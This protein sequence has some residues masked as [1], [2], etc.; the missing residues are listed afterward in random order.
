MNDTNC[1]VA[2]AFTSSAVTVSG[3]GTY[4]SGNFIP[5]T[6]GTYYWIATYTG[7]PPNTSGPVSTTCGD[8]GETSVVNPVTP[9]LTTTAT[10]SVTVGSPIDDTAHLGGT[11]TKPNGTPA[12]GT[13]TFSLY[14]PSNTATCITAIEQSVV[15]VSGN[16]DYSAS[17]GALS[18]TLGSLTPSQLGTYYWIAVY[19]GD[20]PNTNGASTACGDS[21]ESSIVT[22]LPSTIATNQFYY[23]NDTATVTGTGTFDGKVSFE[24]HKV[25]GCTDAA[26]YSAANVAL[27]GTTSGSTASTNNTSYKADATNSGPFYWKVTYSGDSTHFDVTAC[28]ESSSVTITDDGSTTSS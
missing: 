1:K 11:T 13:I 14:G 21:G 8:T 9:T 19:S 15:N 16:G 26:A 4:S 18:G 23:P 12:T 2:P 5:T 22:K 28:V 3:N 6:A 17:A 10:V 20:P 7:D 25:A 27:S 24:L